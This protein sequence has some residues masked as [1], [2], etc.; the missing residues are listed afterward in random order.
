MMC[1]ISLLFLILII[2]EII[3]TLSLAMHAN[4]TFNLFLTSGYILFPKMKYFPSW[5]EMLL[6]GSD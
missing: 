3:Q 1:N 2:L 6:L 5:W 4:Q